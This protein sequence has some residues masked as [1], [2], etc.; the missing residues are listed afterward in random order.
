[1]NGVP[2]RRVPQSYVIATKT[3]ID[4]SA[5]KLPERLTDDYFKREKKQRKST[6]D[7]FEETT[8]VCSHLFEGMYFFIHQIIHYLC[9]Q[10]IWSMCNRMFIRHY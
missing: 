8:E 6:D 2:L 9:R 7:M 4:I 1:M 5:V 10:N 3:K